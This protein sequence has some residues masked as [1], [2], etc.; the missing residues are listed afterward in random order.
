MSGIINNYSAGVLSGPVAQLGARQTGSLKVR[1]STPLGST[2]CSL[3][4]KWEWRL[5]PVRHV[6]DLDGADPFH[7]PEATPVGHDQPRRKA[8]AGGLL[9]QQ[10]SFRRNAVAYQMRGR[11]NALPREDKI[12]CIVS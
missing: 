2:K 4:L 6:V 1:G 5:P 11:N 3:L 8:V 9:Y 12:K 10:M 7:P